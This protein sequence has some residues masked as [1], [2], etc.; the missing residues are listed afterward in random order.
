MVT[1]NF[2]SETFMPRKITEKY[3]RNFFHLDI[4]KTSSHCKSSWASQPPCR[5]LVPISPALPRVL[6]LCWR[7]CSPFVTSRPPTGTRCC[8]RNEA[9]EMAGA[10]GTCGNAIFRAAFVLIEASTAPGAQVG[11]HSPAAVFVLPQFGLDIAWHLKVHQQTLRCAM[12]LFM[13]CM[14][15]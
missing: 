7:C 6:W 1:F 2:Q 11:G 9:W 4:S 14:C 12:S 10:S 3:T 5:A 15:T 8:R 13:C